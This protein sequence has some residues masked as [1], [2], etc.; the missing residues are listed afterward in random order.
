M[1]RRRKPNDPADAS[2]HPPQHIPSGPKLDFEAMMPGYRIRHDG[3]NE[4]RVQRF[5]D[6]LAHTGC[7]KDGARVAGMSANA[8]RRA[9]KA[10]PL[11]AAAW[12]DALERSRQGLIA[13][14]YKR[15]VEGRE[16]IIIR[17]GE[18]HER[19]IQPSDAM[20]GL[21]IKRGDMISGLEGDA[22][23]S[24]EVLTRAEIEDGWA[25]DASG[26]KVKRPSGAERAAALDQRF[27]AMRE[28]MLD[29][30]RARGTCA[31]CLQLLPDRPDPRSMAELVAI[32]VVS[33]ED[34]Y[35]DG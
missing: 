3:W 31:Y 5:L 2:L 23:K 30:A 25:F 9:Q 34:C 19:R 16:T 11:F 12:D 15:A 8:A 33:L 6:T 7:V 17:K 4:A 14:A 18:E 10:Y 22:V 27:K 29:D 13:I 21:L 35:P 20:L 1:A 28:R 32:G 24:D 26:Q